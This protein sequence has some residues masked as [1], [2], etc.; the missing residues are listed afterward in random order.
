MRI[1][2]LEDFAGEDNLRLMFE[3]G[4]LEQRQQNYRGLSP[5]VHTVGAAF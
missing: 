2:S 5:R 4:E 3:V 1:R